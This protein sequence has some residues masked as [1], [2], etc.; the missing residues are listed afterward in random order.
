MNE[1]LRN[2]LAQLYHSNASLRAMARQLGISRGRVRRLL[3]EIQQQ[4]AGQTPAADGPRPRR[5]KPS[6]LDAFEPV[7]AELLKRYPDLTAQ[8]VYEELQARGFEGRYT[9][10]SERVRDLRPRPVR[11]PVVRF[12]TAP[13]AQAQMDYAV[14]DLDFSGEGRRRVSLF[15]YVLGYSRR[16]YLRFVE[17][18]DFETTLREHIRAFEHLGGVAATCLYDNMKVVVARWED[19]EP[20]YNTR[21]LAFATHYGFQPR[22]CLPRRA[23][24]KGKVERP[25]HYVETNLLGGR[26]FRSLE[27]LNEVTACWLAE[28]AD[29]RIHRQTQRRPLDLHAQEQPRLI[30]L[31][32]HPYEVAQVVYRTVNAEGFLVYQHNSYSVPF[33]YLG[34]LL[35]VRITEEEVIVYG[36]QLDELG[37]HRLFP[38]AVTGQRSVLAEH[39][40]PEDR[41]QRLEL[42]EARYAQWGPPA[43]RFLAGLLRQQRCGQ[44]QAQKLLSLLAMYRR[45]DGLAALERAVRFGAYSLSAVERILAATARP[46]PPLAE[47]EEAQ[48]RQ[49]DDLPAGEAVR[50]R[51]TA[52]YG[53][54]LEVKPEEECPFDVDPPPPPPQPDG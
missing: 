40:P 49:L 7:I 12:E 32:Q 20:V 48:R 46:K 29:V 53:Q 18:Q 41:R 19:G 1:Q 28:V 30:P 44:A 2:D 25:F 16:Q 9:I 42:L 39:R 38:R 5:K 6:Q 15:S 17:S 22:A 37:R 23:Q 54:M 8:R 27:H 14:Y 26:N 13:G 31:P 43:S 33:P 3:T 11:E 21:F 10:V 50:P 35:P 52:E 45:A 36:P 51:P 24:T 4:R 34:R 47:L